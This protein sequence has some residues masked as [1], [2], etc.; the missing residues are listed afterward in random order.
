MQAMTIAANSITGR[1]VDNND[2]SVLI[3][4]NISLRKL[5]GALIMGVTTDEKGYFELSNVRDGDYTLTISFIGY[6]NQTLS[7]VNLNKNLPLGEIR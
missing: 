4:A 1:I 7:L 5:T 3:G 6:E 2:H